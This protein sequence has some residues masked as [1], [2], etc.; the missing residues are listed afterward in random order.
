MVRRYEIVAQG[1][2][3]WLSTVLFTLK[4][5]ETMEIIITVDSLHNRAFSDSN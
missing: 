2:M 4:L 3:Y 1:N 5:V